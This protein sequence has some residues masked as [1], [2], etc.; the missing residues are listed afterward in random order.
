MFLAGAAVMALV[1]CSN[2]EEQTRISG[3]VETEGIESVHIKTDKIDTVLKVVEGKFALELPCDKMS[4]GVVQTGRVRLPFIPD[5]TGLKVVIADSSYISSDSGDSL[6][7]RFVAYSNESKAIEAEVMAE[8]RKINADESLSQEEKENSFSDF[9]DTVTKKTVGFAKKTISE[10][11]DNC[12][13]ISALSDIYYELEPSELREIIN[14]MSAAVKEHEFVKGLMASANAKEATAEGKMFTDFE[15]QTVVGHDRSMDANPVYATVKLSDYV[16][17]GK[18]ILVDFWSP[19]C[20]PCKRE[21]PNIKKV[22]EK[23]HGDDFDV[24]SIAVWEREDV[25]VTMKTAD[26]L[27]VTWNQINNAKSIPTELYGIDGIPHLILFGPDGTILKRG[28]HGEKIEQ[29]VSEYLKK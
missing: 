12:L 16:G 10:N 9:Y 4:F 15:V 28:F 29:I 8:Y 13:G 7:E 27:G 19:W 26:E 2:T 21:M 22:Y 24:L 23:Y 18:Y 20:G 6:H 14:G 3:V 25:K 5:G 1:S 11:S 17:K